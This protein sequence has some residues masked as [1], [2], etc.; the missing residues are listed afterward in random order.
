MQRL[1]VV[2]F[3]RRTPRHFR[4]LVRWHAAAQTVPH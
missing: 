4:L 2:V 3:V 1:R